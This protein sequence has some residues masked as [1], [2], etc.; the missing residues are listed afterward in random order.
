VAPDVPR[1]GRRRPSDVEIDPLAYALGGY[2]L[3][4]G[5]VDYTLGS[6]DVELGDARFESQALQLFPMVHLGY[7]F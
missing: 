4:A 2:S 5:L 3:H 7:R 1:S 6:E